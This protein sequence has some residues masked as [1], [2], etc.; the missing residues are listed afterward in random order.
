M[1]KPRTAEDGEF[2]AT[3]EDVQSV[4]RRDSGFDE[5]GGGLSGC[6][7]DGGPV[8]IEVVIGDNGRTVV[9]RLAVAVEYPAEDIERNRQLQDLAL[10]AHRTF[11]EVH[12][13]DPLEYLDNGRLPAHF[14]NLATADLTGSQADID[15]LVVF[16]PGNT[17]DHEQ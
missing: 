3:D 1:G 6:R 10:V 5:L 11:Q 13:A 17:L 12:L 4:D 2:L 8:Y 9:Y 15:N 16:D 14:D 7:I